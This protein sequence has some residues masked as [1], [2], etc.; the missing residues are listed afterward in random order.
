M[1]GYLRSKENELMT[2]SHT[3]GLF[4]MEV[5]K[6]RWMLMILLFAT[7]ITTSRSWLGVKMTPDVWWQ[8]QVLRSQAFGDQHHQN[9]DRELVVV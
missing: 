8:L 9:V 5:G 3:E 4:G 2:A 1:A 6:G 7:L